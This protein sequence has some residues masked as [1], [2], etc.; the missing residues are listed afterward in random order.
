MDYCYC[1]FFLLSLLLLSL[2]K[3]Q[4]TSKNTRPRNG[5]QKCLHSSQDIPAH[6]HDLLRKLPVLVCVKIA[7]ANLQNCRLSD[8]LTIKLCTELQ[9]CKKILHKDKV[10]VSKEHNEVH[11]DTKT[12]YLAIQLV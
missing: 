11:R 6:A 7:F 12:D 3:Q 1:Y 8:K 9:L 4:L 2:C 5:I 10:G